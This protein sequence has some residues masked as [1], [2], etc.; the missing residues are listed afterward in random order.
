MRLPKLAVLLVVLPGLAVCQENA[1]RRVG[2][3]AVSSAT[4]KVASAQVQT[5]LVRL[6]NGAKFD[7]KG[8]GSI[9]ATQLRT[10]S[11]GDALAEAGASACQFVLLIK[12]EEAQPEQSRVGR[13]GKLI[14]FVYEVMRVDTHTDYAMGRVEEKFSNSAE[15][16]IEAGEKRLV[17][18]VTADLSAK[19]S[20]PPSQENEPSVAPPT[21]VEPGQLEAATQAS[22]SEDPAATGDSAANPAPSGAKTSSPAAFCA[23]ISGDIPHA[24]SLAGVCEFAIALPLRMPNFICEETTARFHEGSRSPTDVISGTLRYEDRRE[25]FSDVKVNGRKAPPDV[26]EQLSGLWSSGEFGSNLRSIFDARNTPIFTF[27]GE[28]KLKTSVA[29]AFSFRIEEQK[30]P[31]WWVTSDDQKLAP[32]YGGEL[33]VDQKTGEVVLLRQS[34]QSFPKKFPTQSVE[35][36]TFYSKT[37]FDDGTGF[38]LPVQSQVR[39]K[40]HDVITVNVLQFRNCHKF[41]AKSRMLFDVPPENPLP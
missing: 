7:K 9:E 40:Y 5:H 35:T 6:L 28:K 19:G 12:V 32:A 38:V 10:S 24:A 17:A 27:L 23:W 39:T 1:V 29:W 8:M 4:D 30:E 18:E 41:R 34:A 15:S 22:E 14:R 36:L 11:R 25:S 3:A 2:V 21:L 37:S 31:Q 13:K 16:A 20:L 33:W 26:V